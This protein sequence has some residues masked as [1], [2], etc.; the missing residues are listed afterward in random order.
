MWDKDER[1]EN[2]AEQQNVDDELTTRVW[3][4]IVDGSMT[5]VTLKEHTRRLQDAGADVMS[6]TVLPYISSHAATQVPHFICGEGDWKVLQ[7][8]LV[9]M[10]LCQCIAEWFLKRKDVRANLVED[11][12]VK[13]RQAVWQ[14]IDSVER[15][16]QSLKLNMIVFVRAL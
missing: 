4:D 14:W 1:D 6:E 10:A 12:C 13:E 11:L 3:E 2:G 9:Q 7:Q 16:I 15:C 8:A 5:H